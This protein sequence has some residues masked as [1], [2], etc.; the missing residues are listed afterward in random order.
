[1]NPASFQAV[2]KLGGDLVR[3]GVLAAP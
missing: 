1:M 3:S 2:A